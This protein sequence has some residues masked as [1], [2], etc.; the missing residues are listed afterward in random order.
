[1]F[2]EETKFTGQLSDGPRSFEI[3]LVAKVGEDCR[4]EIDPVAV[5]GKCYVAFSRG[6][7]EP[8]GLAIQLQLSAKSESGILLF[9]NFI[10]VTG[11]SSGS[12]G[13]F[14]KLSALQATIKVC[15]N[16]T[17]G[18][19]LKVAVKMSLRGFKSFRPRPVTSR[20][21]ELSVHGSHKISSPDQVSGA[22]LISCSDTNPP[23]GWYTEAETLIDFIWKGLQFGHGGRIQV[24]LVQ[25]YRPDSV[26]ATLYHGRGRSPHLPSIHF[27]D[28]SDFIAALVA[29]W[30]SE[31]PFDEAVWLAVGWLNSDTSIDEVRYLTLM[32]ALETILE[33]LTPDAQTMVI[34]R[35]NFV[36]IREQLLSIL[37]SADISTE[38]RSILKG[39]ISGL[40]RSTLSQKIRSIIGKYQLPVEIFDDNA[41]RDLNKQRNS[42]THTGR[43]VEGLSLW[44]SILKARE[45]IALIVFSEL[46]YKGRHES[47]V[48]G[49]VRR[50]LTEEN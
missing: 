38:A 33:N 47:Y 48:D 19:S 41:I 45:F 40:N 11:W 43:S 28:Q 39:S 32:T 22:I 36:P 12:K 3:G 27:M 21:G 44:D 9:S 34:G 35:E 4:L 30:E 17:D 16:A 2:F 14:L 31:H 46:G 7:G 29:R 24:P 37:S 5:S 20:C 15:R 25:V 13:F 42:I 49:Y 10:E 26:T 1:M 50:D 23:D 6:T 18:T 8:G